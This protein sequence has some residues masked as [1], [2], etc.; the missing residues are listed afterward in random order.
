MRNFALHFVQLLMK[1]VF[2]TGATGVMGFAALK[3]FMKHTDRIK[4]TV[5]ARPGKKN[6]KLLAPYLDRINVVWGD[7]TRFE[8]VERATR[9]ADYVLHV[10]G[11][12]SPKCDY[13]P[14]RTRST[15]LLAARNVVRAVQAQPNHDD[16]RVCYI[17][18]VAQTSDHQAPYHFGRTGDPIHISMYDHYGISKVM[19]ELLFAESGLKHWVSLRQSGIMHPGILDNFDPIMFHVT[20][21]G[22]LE[23]ATVD[24][25]ARL[26]VN[27]CLEDLPDDFWCRFYNISSGKGYRLTNYEF[28]NLLLKTLGLPKVEK[29]ARPEWFV[30][31]NFHGQWYEDADVLERWLHF[32]ANI[33]VEEYFRQMKRQLKW[34]FTLAPLAPAPIVKMAFKSQARKPRFGTIWWFEHNDENRIA[35]FYGSRAEHDAI[36]RWEEQELTHPDETNPIRLDHGYDE[37]KPREQWTIEDMRQAAEFRG[38]KCLSETMTPGD[39]RTPLEWECQFGH[40]FRMSPESVLEGGH[41][42]PECLP[43]PWNYDEIAKGNPFFAQVWNPT[44]K[45]DAPRIYG[46]ELLQGWEGDSTKPF[47]KKDYE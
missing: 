2:L 37:L 22:V 24:D 26:L 31:R 8:D 11:L 27:L 23:W 42:C 17:G 10:G 29:L 13:W 45:N 43:A 16:I 38:G 21:R 30:T 3:E 34:Y 5:L 25:S 44:H 47:N 33:P 1:N 20:L 9:G 12:V 28:E 18:S 40:R 32:R 19:G 15:N 7:L 46:E 35:A 41:W 14:N 6:S 39:W 4:L 36:R